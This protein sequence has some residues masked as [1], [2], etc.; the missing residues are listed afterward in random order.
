MSDSESDVQNKVTN[1]FKKNVKRWVEID[2]TIR[3]IRAKAK[4]L[5]QEKKDYEEFILNFLESVDEKKCWY[6]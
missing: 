5:T 2:D 6:C 3:E 4:E 1:E